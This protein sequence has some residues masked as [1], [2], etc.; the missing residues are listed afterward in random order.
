MT[1]AIHMRCDGCDAEAKSAP[2]RRTFSS[3]NGRGYG[4]GRWVTPSID[5]A[6][7]PTG[8]VWSDPT[9][10]YPSKRNAPPKRG[11]YNGSSMVPGAPSQLPPGGFESL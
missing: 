11:A 3:F 4:F 9:T 8:W 1:T 7:S 5:D 2:V 10:I 6:V